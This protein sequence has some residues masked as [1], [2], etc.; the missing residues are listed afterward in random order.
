MTLL[1][2]PNCTSPVCE[3]CSVHAQGNAHLSRL[4]RD[5][6]LVYFQSRPRIGKT[7]EHEN[8]NFRKW[9]LP[10]P[11]KIELYR[12]FF[13]WNLTIASQ[14]TI[15]LWMII[16][17]QVS[18]MSIPDEQDPLQ[19][20]LREVATKQGMILPYILSYKHNWA[21]RPWNQTHLFLVLKIHPNPHRK[22]ITSHLNTH[23][24]S[25]SVITGQPTPNVLPHA[26]K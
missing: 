12:L 21:T 17:N 23:P 26:P 2:S 24:T 1:G 14:P 7:I 3:G 22:T 16:K 10:K 20:W 11:G 15:Y 18:P 9:P 4:T 25:T 5:R 19:S 8:A 6:Q 13:F